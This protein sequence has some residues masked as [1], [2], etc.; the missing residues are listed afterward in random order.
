M[1]MDVHM[2]E[3]DGLEAT[4]RIRALES[5]RRNLQWPRIVAMTADAMPEDREKCLAAGMSDYLTKPLE[6]EA[7]RAVVADVAK[8][9]GHREAPVAEASVA[10]SPA[11]PAR[12][13]IAQAGFIDWSRLDELREY[14]TPDGAIVNG[15]IASFIEQSSEKLAILET[16]V[17]ANDTEALRASAHALKGAALNIG[18]IVVAEQAKRIEAAAKSGAIGDVAVPCPVLVPPLSRSPAGPRQTKFV[19]TPCQ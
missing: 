17:R 14:D 19:S 8:H 6:F 16:N 1:F 11:T 18:A 7:V 4:R 2:P 9:A 10:V 5:E 3:M 12:I 13:E 15:V